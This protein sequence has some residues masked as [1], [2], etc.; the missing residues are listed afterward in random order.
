MGGCLEAMFIIS[1]QKNSNKNKEEIF[2]EKP[3]NIQLED[4]FICE[5]KLEPSDVLKHL[6]NHFILELDRKYQ[7]VN[8]T[9]DE[10][11]F[12]CAKCG[13]DFEDKFDFLDHMGILHKGV[14]EFVPEKYRDLFVDA[15]VPVEKEKGLQQREMEKST[16][17]AAEVGSEEQQ[18][19][20]VGE[21]GG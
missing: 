15:E 19:M 6:C 11:L 14:V 1:D 18:D 16:D 21:V 10:S 5:E 13:N 17:E 4:C 2:N 9:T 12:S 8:Q 7:D 20:D 3:Q